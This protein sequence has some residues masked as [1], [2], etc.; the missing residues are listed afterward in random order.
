MLMLNRLISKLF[1]KILHQ[2]SIKTLNYKKFIFNKL[3]LTLLKQ[4]FE[5]MVLICNIFKN[6]KEP[7][8]LKQL[9]ELTKG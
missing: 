4:H 2:L 6:K 9:I 3:A 5:K 7:L 1:E 8:L